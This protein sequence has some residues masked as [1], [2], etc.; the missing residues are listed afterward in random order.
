MNQDVE[1]L[2]IDAS[3]AAKWHLRD[4]QDADK[5]L[6][7]LDEFVTGQIDLW[8]PEQIR[9]EVPA[10]ITRAARGRTPR[11]T[12]ADGQQAIVDFLDWGLA[13]LDSAELVIAA[14]PLV[15]QHDCTLYDALYLALAEKLALPFI[16][17]DAKLYGRV[18]RLPYV[19]W[20]GDYATS[21]KEAPP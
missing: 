18:Q 8:A 19:V 14:Y 11:L 16:T 13:T 2:V 3:V 4:E 20:I 21:K 15:H 9:C 1:A 17:A 6:L 7:V 5:A 10:A 12:V